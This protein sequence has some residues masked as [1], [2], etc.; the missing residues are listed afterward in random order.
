VKGEALGLGA[1]AREI[2]GRIAVLGLVVSVVVVVVLSWSLA[3][4]AA[5]DGAIA[6]LPSNSPHA[7][8]HLAASEYPARGV[9]PQPALPVSPS[10]AVEKP[11]SEAP[12]SRRAASA[13][14]DAPVDPTSLS[15]DGTFAV[16]PGRTSWVGS[17]PS[18][19]YQVEVERGLPFD[20]ASTS[21]Q[22][23][24]V[25]ADPRSWAAVGVARIQRVP[26]GA[27]TRLLVASPG[28][29]DRLCAPLQTLGE[30]SC[31][32]GNLVVLNAKRWA[33]GS[34]NVPA[35]L[36]AY[37]AYLVNHEVGHALGF[38]HEYCPA[39]GARAPVMQQQ[40]KGLDGCTPNGWPYP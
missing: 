22:I 1:V 25:L 3:A 6:P 9:T 20:L 28:T 10:V 15:G 38:G 34:D 32:S 23:D 35:P 18:W 30:L 8:G 17:G 40:T 5:R 26:T 29:T 13:K 36:A 39:V 12:V 27:V 19:T 14:A 16:A 33:I 31:R 4:G 7:A 24:A 21:Q 11:L 2:V 37:R